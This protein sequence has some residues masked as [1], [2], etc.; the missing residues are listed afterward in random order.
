MLIFANSLKLTTNNSSGVPQFSGAPSYLLG[1]EAFASGG[2]VKWQN[3]SSVSVGSATKATKDGDGNVISSTYMKSA[4]TTLAT[5]KGSSSG[6]TFS[7]TD[8]SNYKFI[9]FIFGNE[10]APYY[11][12]DEVTLQSAVIT[13]GTSYINKKIFLRSKESTSEYATVTFSSATSV[14]VT[15]YST[16]KKVFIYG[17]G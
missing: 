5:N 11:C 16:Q 7:V 1:I 13:I 17:Y 15:T 4:I 2:D 9:K 10:G 6:D 8:I 12:V 3:A 14:K